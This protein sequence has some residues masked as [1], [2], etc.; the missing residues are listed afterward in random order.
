VRRVGGEVG[1]FSKGIC[2]ESVPLSQPG[3]RVEDGSVRKGMGNR[4][5]MHIG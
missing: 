4:N 2:P 1:D 5:S 3:Q